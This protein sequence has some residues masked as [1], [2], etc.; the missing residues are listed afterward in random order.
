MRLGYMPQGSQ[1]TPTDYK[2][3]EH[4]CPSVLA[5]SNI[6]S[7]MLKRGGIV[8]R[9]ALEYFPPT[10][11][12]GAGPD[13]RLLGLGLDLEIETDDG[14]VFV[15]TDDAITDAMECC[16]LG[17]YYDEVYSR[18]APDVVRTY[19]PRSA[20]W[21]Q[22]FHNASWDEEQELFYQSRRDGYLVVQPGSTSQVSLHQPRSTT[23]WKSAIA[24]RNVE[25]KRMWI[26][27]EAAARQFLS[28]RAKNPASYMR[29]GQM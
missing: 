1:V 13:A 12:A 14:K 8:T 20:T 2:E 21:R 22:A 27:A 19:W 16:L 24:K 7:A 4:N 10:A 28:T 17:G 6:L 26:G 15:G 3:Y 11:V 18:L 9:I 29:C 25:A 23:Q 5:D